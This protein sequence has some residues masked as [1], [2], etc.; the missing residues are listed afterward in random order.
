MRRLAC[1]AALLLAACAPLQRQCAR[2]PWMLCGD[3]VVV[4]KHFVHLDDPAFLYNNKTV[5]KRAGEVYGFRL[6]FFLNPHRGKSLRLS[7]SVRPHRS[8]GMAPSPCAVTSGN[9]PPDAPQIQAAPRIDLWDSAYTVTVSPSKERVSLGFACRDYR[10]KWGRTDTLAL[11]FADPDEPAT[12]MLLPF[13][14]S[15]HGPLY[16]FVIGSV[17]IVSM[18]AGGQIVASNR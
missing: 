3:R 10:P 9:V 12:P 11:A 15:F 4:S 16:S 13:A 18:T 8:S 2:H 1:A 17:L 7:A 6:S 5:A 14:T